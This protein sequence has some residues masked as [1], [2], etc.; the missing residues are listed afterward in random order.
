MLSLPG[1]MTRTLA[2]GTVN[3]PLEHEADRVAERVMRTAE[4]VDLATPAAADSHRKSITRDAPTATV[5]TLRLAPVGVHAIP[6]SV[7]RALD[8]QTRG[9]FEPRLGLDLEAVRIHD[10]HEAATSAR[11]VRARAYTVGS[12]IVFGAGEYRP[13]T[14]EGQALLAHELAHVRQDAIGG[15]S[16]V[17]RRT[18]CPSCHKPMGTQQVTLEPLRDDAVHYLPDVDAAEFF[19]YMRAGLNWGEY[20]GGKR[21][22]TRSVHYYDYDG[23]S[24]IVGYVLTFDNP[25]GSNFPQPV[26]TIDVYG[27]ILAETSNDRQAIESVMSPIDFIGPG[28]LSRPLIGGARAL[29][30]G[31][32]RAAPGW[33]FSARMVISDL[34]AA[35]MRG[36][37]DFSA[38]ALRE[39]P[40]ALVMSEG[41]Q[42][43]SGS[44]LARGLATDVG[45]SAFPFNA[46]PLQVT[47]PSFA[48][49]STELGLETPGMIGYRSTAA[50]MLGAYAG[51]LVTGTR[52]GFQS[53]ST[54][55]S[56]RAATGMSGSIFQSAHIVPQA[57]YRILRVRG[58]QVGGQRVSADRALTTILP[59]WAHA[60]FDRSWIAEWN[61]AVAAGRT[62]TAGDVYNWVSRA[63]ND[64]DEWVINFEGQGAIN[65]RLRTEMFGELNLHPQDVI[66]RGRP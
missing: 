24:R 23:G 53:H 25:Q 55:S 38:F 31:L 6:G 13:S 29:A 40:S 27:N 5:P 46:S 43:A 56:I 17:L 1:S 26:V 4:N 8:A 18:P 9:F 22:E 57:L 15:S 63:I 65:D 20:K 59:R 11:A 48:D 12:D 30:G 36:T 49:I 14:G 42:F 28:F 64:V 2:V 45:D 54:A 10:G 51:N 66:I 33:A 47:G 52:L 7:G 58:W 50:A 21:T 16:G 3:D 61:N 32:A 60:A 34:T 39:T 62:I 19:T 37:A 35:G 41:G 44:S